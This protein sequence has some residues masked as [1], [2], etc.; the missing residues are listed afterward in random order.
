MGLAAQG[1]HGRAPAAHALDRACD[2]FSFVARDDPV[3]ALRRIN[4]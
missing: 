1:K 4:V 2:Q 3:F